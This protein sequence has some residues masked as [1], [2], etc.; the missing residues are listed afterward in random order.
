MA[1]KMASIVVI[2]WIKVVSY[3]FGNKNYEADDNEPDNW[4]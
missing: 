1:R 4:H 3:L 2:L